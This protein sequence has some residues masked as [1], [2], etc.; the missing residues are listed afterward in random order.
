[1]GCSSCTDTEDVG[2]I[3]LRNV[4]NYLPNNTTLTTQKIWI[5]TNTAV[6]N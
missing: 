3:I 4:G 6:T 2:T 1:M 5:S